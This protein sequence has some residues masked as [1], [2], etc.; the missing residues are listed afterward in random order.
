[1][2]TLLYLIIGLVVLIIILAMIAPKNYDVSRTILINKPISEVYNYLKFIKNQENWSPW[3][4]KDPNMVQ[5]HSG[6]DGEIGFVTAWEGNKD[7]GS[8]EQELTG[9]KENEEVSSELRFFKPWKSV[10]S[11][12]LRVAEDG[13][14][15]KVTWGFRGDN[16]FP[17][18]IMMLFMN[19]DKSVGADFEKGLEKLKNVLES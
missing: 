6:T 3:R 14:G 4:E 5:T 16:K 2:T 8:G 18:S 10:S 19:M 1:M 17:F 15:T 12:Y 7:V 13:E 9:L 11:A